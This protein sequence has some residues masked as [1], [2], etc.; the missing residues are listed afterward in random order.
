[1]SQAEQLCSNAKNPEDFFQCTLKYHPEMAA[2]LTGKESAK[3]ERDLITQF[4]NPEVSIRSM[5]GK[6]A[7]ENVGST[8]VA[9]NL[10]VSN[11]LLNRASISELGRSSEKLGL[12][13]AE[14]EEFKAK[15]QLI[16]ELY[17]YRQ[18]HEELE[19]TVE[20]LEAFEKIVSQFRSRLARGPEQE[21][22]LNLVELALGDYQLRKNHLV[23][24]KADIEARY[25]ALYGLQFEMK[26]NWLPGFRTQWPSIRA[27]EIKGETFSL[28][29]A[30]A[31]RQRA[32]AEK[33][34][35]NA[36]SWPQI[37]A[38]PVYER[39]TEGPT[40]YNSMG[41]AMS[42]SVPLLSLNGG[43]RGMAEQNKLKTQLLYDF[44]VKKENLEKQTLLQKYQSAVESLK[45]SVDAISLKKK[46]SRIDSLFRQ[47]LTSG[48]TVIEA[49][50]QILEFTEAQHEHELTALDSYLYL[51]QLSGREINEVLK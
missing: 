46:H 20:A 15:S 14:E 28:R 22:T 35:A 4:A 9:V 38:G 10:D 16:R 51:C 5:G 39:T 12:A 23:V 25:K 24:E 17:R 8:E 7:G 27:Q 29:K 41:F 44:A 40:R 50:R 13:T 19:L 32:M 21:I 34:L 11:L 3:S 43:A 47:G 45:R 30:D 31:E 33:S 18:V 36:E 48:A 42:V 26:K 2:A 1:M 6:N 37:S 49:H